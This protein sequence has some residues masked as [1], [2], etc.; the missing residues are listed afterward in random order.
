MCFFLPFWTW[1]HLTRLPAG[2]SAPA[3]A[4][5][6]DRAQL[7][8]GGRRLRC[9]LLSLLPSWVSC[10]W[11][12]VCVGADEGQ[13][14][15]CASSNK[16]WASLHA[17]P[18]GARRG[19]PAGE[20]TPC[21]AASKRGKHGLHGVILGAQGCCSG[22]PG[23]VVAELG[24][25]A[26]WMC[27]STAWARCLGCRGCAIAAPPPFASFCSSAGPRSC[28]LLWVAITVVCGEELESCL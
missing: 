24:F 4:A 23:S 27:S 3:A 15:S 14:L 18:C 20:L 8:P 9:S 1:W 28:F 22:C 11:A 19:G 10:A 17:S 13:V 2:A 7:S 25:A 26:V 16:T 6:R 21:L 12:P 5:E